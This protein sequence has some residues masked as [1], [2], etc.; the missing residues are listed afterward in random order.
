MA[1]LL[2]SFIS[3]LERGPIWE[4]D[5]DSNTAKLYES[6]ATVLSELEDYALRVGEDS[7]P[8]NTTNS[9]DLWQEDFFLPRCGE[10]NTIEAARAEVLA[11]FTAK[12]PFKQELIQEIANLFDV[13]E[14]L[15][16][17]KAAW[18]LGLRL[19]D[20]EAVTYAECGEAECGE[21]SLT[22]QL[23]PYG[24]LTAECGEAECGE[25][26][27]YT[28]TLPFG[29]FC[30]LNRMVPAWVLLDFDLI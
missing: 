25:S 12:K 8:I 13:G 3:L 5:K 4:A 15:L 30:L 16:T 9:L 24:S 22:T 11:L 19:L 29:F 6:I 2:D 20:Y 23:V 18:H 26:L 28:S 21:T 17:R 14:I 10:P 27:L 1:K 7:D